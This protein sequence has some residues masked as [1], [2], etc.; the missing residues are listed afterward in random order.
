MNRAALSARV[1]VVALASAASALT[2]SCSSDPVLSDTVEAQGNET[3]GI[4]EGP[5][6]RA[7]QRCTACHQKGGEASNSPF[8]LAGT[9]FAQPNRQVGVENAEIR[10][11]DSEGTKHIATTNCVGNFFVKPSEWEPRFPILVEVAKGGATRSMKS[12]IGRETDCAGC[13][14]IKIPPADPL[15]EVGHIYLFS[16]DEIGMPNG[17]ASCPVDPRRPGS[18]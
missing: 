13:H 4:P 14:S 8:T 6:H 9:V 15:S 7:G 2:A 5:L 1:I 3:K 10:L 16:T 12:P 17:S 18:P 11:T